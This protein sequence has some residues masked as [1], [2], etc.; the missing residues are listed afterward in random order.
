MDFLDLVKKRCSVREYDA[1][2]P[3]EDEKVERI[4]EAA[5]VA[6]SAANL[7]PVRLV[8]VDDEDGMRRLGQ[9]ANVYGAPLAIIVCADREKAWRRPSDGKSTADID[10]SI[11]TD[12]M[13]MEATDL[14]L[15]SVWICWFDP[16]LVAE[17]FGLPDSL[18]PVNV[19]AIGYGVGPGK[20]I[21]RHDVERLPLESLLVDGSRAGMA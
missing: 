17:A 8:V 14:G 1:G 21:D 2:R 9:A 6:P 5:R 15:G 20:P 11:A 13:M 16:V 4:L 19:L 18:E 10:A 12:H 7:Q 3:V